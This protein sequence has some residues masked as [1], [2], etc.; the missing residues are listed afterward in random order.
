MAKPIHLHPPRGAA[1]PPGSARP[2]QVSAPS[3]EEI[4][5]AVTLFNSGD[6]TAT[7]VFARQLLQR[8]PEHGFGWKILGV[9]LKSLGRTAEA[10]EPMRKA[11]ALLPGQA[12]VH[13]NLGITLKNL[14]L[15]EEAVASY[16]RA[17]Q[18]KPDLA[19]AHCNLG[20]ALKDLGRSREAEACYRRSLQINPN[21]AEAHS[22]LGNI[23]KETGRLEEAEACY[24]RALTVNPGLAEIHGNLGAILCKIGRLDE[25]EASCRRALTIRPDLADVHS[26]LGVTLRSLGR[27]AEAEAACRRA[28]E[29]SPASADAHCNLGTTLNDLGRLAEAEA[30][31]RRAVAIRPDLAEAHSNLGNILSG[32]GRLSEAETSCRRALVI[33]PDLA[34]AHYALGNILKDLG[35]QEGAEDCYRRALA[36]RPDYFAA[37]SSLLFSLSYSA[38]HTPDYILAEARNYGKMVTGNV[39]RRFSSWGCAPM[40]ERLRVGIVSGDLYKHP[41]GFFLESVLAAIDQLRIELIVYTTY[42]KNDELT[43]RIK[44]Y[45]SAWR[46]LVGLNDETAARLI[47]ADGIHLLLDLSGHMG[48]NRLPVFGWKPA[49]IQASWMGFLATT[50]VKEID[51]VLGDSLA[52]PPEDEGNFSEKVWRLPEIYCCFTPPEHAIDPGPLP[53]LSNGCITFGS[54]NHLAKITEQVV[55]LWSRVLK[56]VPGSRLFLKSRQLNDP[57]MRET[58]AARFARHGIKPACLLLEGT[59]PRPELLAA[60][61]RVDI[62]LD[63]FP[64]NGG[65]TSMECLWMAVPFITRRG[66]RFLSR[67]GESLAV[68]AGLADWI[69]TD[70]D[71][72][73]NKAVTH[74]ADLERLAALRTGLRRQVLA[75]PLF[76][77]PRFA[78]HFEDAL[79]GMWHR[80]HSVTVTPPPKDS[81]LLTIRSNAHSESNGIIGQHNRT[82]VSQPYSASAKR[83]LCLETANWT[84]I[85]RLAIHLSEAGFEVGCLCTDQ[86]ILNILPRI[87][88]YRWG[89]THVFHHRLEQVISEFKPD[90]LIFMDDPSFRMISAVITRNPEDIVSRQR[91]LL[92]RSLGCLETVATRLLRSSLISLQESVAVPKTMTSRSLDELSSFGESLG[93]QAIFKEEYTC[94]GTGVITTG[95]EQKFL[96]TARRLIAEEKQYIVQEFIHGAITMRA[97]VAYEGAVLCGVSFCKVLTSAGGIGYSTVIKPMHNEGMKTTTDKI[98]RLFRMNGPFSCDFIVANE[99]GKAYLIEINPRPTTVFHLGHLFGVSFAHALAAVIDATPQIQADSPQTDREV[100]LFPKELYRDRNSSRLTTAFH[101]VPWSY[102]AIVTHYL[103]PLT[104]QKGPA[105]LTDN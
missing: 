70:D 59:S 92:E 99:T 73:V 9:V 38:S 79:W 83:V 97:A 68:N 98:G 4:R 82:S 6:F 44:P 23:L 104:G 50:G 85:E 28:L 45:F 19:E 57:K 95:T 89:D 53:A 36:I 51:Y 39:S 15:L 30:S 26:T 32:M 55:T 40:P 11:A 3:A 93:W 52:T 58:V 48:N 71:D 8:Y 56:A 61:Q 37:Y 64:Y 27:L 12:D 88:R 20:V 81:G 72:Y 22:N 87:T 49:P 14:G 35:R 41:V 66:N 33:R 80:H 34:E 24:R 65:T 77:A 86:S 43:A 46:T 90:L 29:I 100:A 67:C 10:L 2:I 16:R 102:P 74:S 47:H 91:Q 54:F 103:S 21:M 62:A 69:A 42:S 60:Y 84:G 31:F 75:S 105:T 13:S 96:E 78:R 17:L 18:L 1:Q 101:D 76:D 94:S 25:A 7:E 63:P 5:R